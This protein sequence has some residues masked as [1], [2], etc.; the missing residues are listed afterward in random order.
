MTQLKVITSQ[1]DST[2][3]RSIA[4]GGEENILILCTQLVQV[5]YEE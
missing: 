2:E 3:V 4:L 5:T 1:F